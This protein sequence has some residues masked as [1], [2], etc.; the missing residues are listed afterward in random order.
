MI[1]LFIDPV[2]ALCMGLIESGGEIEVGLLSRD[3]MYALIFSCSADESSD[4]GERSFLRPI[5]IH[6]RLANAVDLGEYF[7][8]VLKR[9]R[10]IAVKRAVSVNII[11]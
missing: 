2:F 6:N 11:N 10:R 3:P 8:T 1:N 5:G 4:P 7:V 9:S